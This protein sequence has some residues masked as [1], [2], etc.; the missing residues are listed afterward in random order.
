MSL[1]AE[2]NSEIIKRYAALAIHASGTRSE[3]L[4]VKEHYTSA[5]PLHRL[6]ILFAS[7]KLGKDERKHWK[8][9]NGISDATEKLI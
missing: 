4:V 7:H 2:S 5:S 8:L 1:Y 9:A 6:A 3:A